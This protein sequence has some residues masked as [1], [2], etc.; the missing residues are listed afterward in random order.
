MYEADMNWEQRVAADAAVSERVAFIRK[1]YLHVA[2]AIVAFA[3]LLAALVN[4]GPNEAMMNLVFTRGGWFIVIAIYMLAGF[5]AQRMANSTTSIATQYLGLGLFTVA[6]AFVFWPLIWFCT[7]QLRYEGVLAQ[8]VVLTLALAGGLT[9]SVFV[10][11]ADFSW[12]RTGLNV[13]LLVALGLIALSMAGLMSLGIWFAIAMVVLM[14]GCILYE[15]SNVLH[16]YRTTQYVGASLAI[17][18]AVATLFW[19]IIQIFMSMRD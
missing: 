11:K 19:Y 15:T 14:C 4:F 8:S 13:L 16:H 5:I 10:T 3:V 17:F 2:G 18:S 7:N 12:M 9:M 6:E 1:T